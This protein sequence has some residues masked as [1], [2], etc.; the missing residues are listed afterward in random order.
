MNKTCRLTQNFAMT[1][2]LTQ[3]FAMKMAMMPLGMGLYGHFRHQLLRMNYW[4]VH[5]H[6]NRDQ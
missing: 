3:N 6:V 5:V 2:K 4:L 1:M